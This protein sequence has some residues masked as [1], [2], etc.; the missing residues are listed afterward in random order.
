MASA[1]GVAK[2][3]TEAPGGKYDA[4]VRPD[5]MVHRSVYVDPGIFEEEM[6]RIFAR[7]WVFLLHEAEIPQLNDFKQ[8]T[9]GRRATLVTRGKNNRIHALLNRCTHRGSAL[10]TLDRGNAP[11]F[12]CPYHGWTFSNTGE[13]VTIP[14]RGGY[15]AAFDQQAHHL[16]VFPRVENYRGFVFGSLDP[17]VE[18]LVDWLGPAREIFDWAIDQDHIGSTGARVATGMTMSMHANWKFPFDNICDGYHI[19][20]AHR[21]A[22]M[23]NHQHYGAGKGLDHIKSEG[24][25]KN[26]YFG[27]G[28]K[29]ADQRPELGSPWERARP[30]PGRE[31]HAA[32]IMDK[33]AGEKGQ[34]F[35]DLTA[36]S[37]INLGLFPN[38]GVQGHG[39]FYVIE[40]VSVGYTHVRF[41]MLLLNDAPNE[42]NTLRLR[43]GEDFNNIGTRDDFEVMERCHHGLA[44]IPEVEWVDFS[45][46]SNRE[47]KMPNGAISADYTDDSPRRLGYQ[48][49]KE[50]MNRTAS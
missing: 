6:T 20:F 13:L 29:V 45:R 27:H 41:Y 30:I 48:W 43:F 40:P 38:L 3:Q 39:T 22:A 21:S 36:R 50:L 23:M 47:T 7:S 28:H 11:R 19:P 35:L 4:L 2:V 14:F 34:R 49:W 33:H 8:I 18:P 1:P 17:R 46:G 16:G 9:V 15:G 12:Q 44:T 31:T 37:G 24:A 10:C 42:M 25:L 32:A 5:G 26:Y